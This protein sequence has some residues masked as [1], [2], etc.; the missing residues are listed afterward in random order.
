MDRR[1]EHTDTVHVVYA[2]TEHAPHKTRL[3][4]TLLFNLLHP[5]YQRKRLFIFNFGKETLKTYKENFDV[6]TGD[7]ICHVLLMRWK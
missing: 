6:A 3:L 5:P 7:R 4:P 1:G 2:R